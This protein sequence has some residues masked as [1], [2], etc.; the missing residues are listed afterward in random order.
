MK[1]QLLAFA[2]AS[3]S[4]VPVPST[5]QSKL[6]REAAAKVLANVALNES[7]QILT[8]PFDR[9]EMDC[10]KPAT[11]IA[12]DFLTQDAILQGYAKPRQNEDYPSVCYLVPTE[13]ALA[14]GK[15][16]GPQDVKWDRFGVTVKLA[17]PKLDRVTGILQSGPTTAMVDYVVTFV[18][19]PQALA[20]AKMS[21]PLGSD[22]ELFAQ[23]KRQAT[24]GSWGSIA[25]KAEFRKYD[26]GWRLVRLVRE[27]VP[28]I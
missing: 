27:Y 3:V 9:V 8:L 4:L 10:N 28:R 21:A 1:L 25:R 19:T 17:T 7:P 18:S 15:L 12:R 13:K 22:A 5:A 16:K 11:P 14:A 24:P 26:D 6:T 20:I 23:Y 2:L